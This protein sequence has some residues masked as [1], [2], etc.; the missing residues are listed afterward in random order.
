MDKSTC[1]FKSDANQN[2]LKEKCVHNNDSQRLVKIL[3][4]LSTL[5]LKPFLKHWDVYHNIIS[6]NL[7]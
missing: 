1:S 5:K 7:C 3:K 6:T 4:Y 2:T